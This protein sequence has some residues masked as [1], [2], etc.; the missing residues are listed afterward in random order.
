MIG[1]LFRHLVVGGASGGNLGQMSDGD[2][3]PFALGDLSHDVGHLLGHAT[4][5]AGVYLVEDD[6]GQLDS[7]TDEGFEREHHASYFAARGHFAHGQHR[8]AAV[9]TEEEGEAVVPGGGEFSLVDSDLES[10]FGD[11]QVDEH[12]L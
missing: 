11:A 9:G 4:A 8:S 12:S 5:Y 6:G 10:G 7:M 1:F 3:L 2:H